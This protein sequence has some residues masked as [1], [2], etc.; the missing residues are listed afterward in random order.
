MGSVNK[1]ILVGNLGQDPKTSTGASGKTVC[2][3]SLATSDK[4][5]G[6]ERTEWHNI[7][8]FAR[9]AETAHQHP[10]RGRQVYIEGRIQTRKYQDK[11]TG[12]DRYR[13]EIIGQTLQMLGSRHSDSDDAPGTYDPGARSAPPRPAPP[14]AP[15]R[16]VPQGQDIFDEFSDP[17]SEDDIPPF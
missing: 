4:F 17:P 11:D 10:S 12:Q 6:E 9:L 5:G 14:K 13:T 16:P 3:F 8:L 2:R 1:A 7:V 15:A